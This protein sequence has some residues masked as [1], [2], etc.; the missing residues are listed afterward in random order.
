MKLESLE[1]KF[2]AFK[3]SE[4]IPAFSWSSHTWRFCKS[5]IIVVNSRRQPIARPLS[6][7]TCAE[8]LLLLCSVLS[9]P[10]H[11]YRCL[12]PVLRRCDQCHL[13]CALFH[14]KNLNFVKFFMRVKSSSSELMYV[15]TWDY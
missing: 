11:A 6:H 4:L 14:K 5:T 12:L 7:I 8:L 10:G 15:P 2:K 3:F 1:Q 9:S 13:G